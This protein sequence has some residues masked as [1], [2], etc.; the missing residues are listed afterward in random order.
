MKRRPTRLGVAAVTACAG[1]MVAAGCGPSGGPAA[2]RPGRPV[3]VAC[4][5]TLAPRA[6]AAGLTSG[7]DDA[8]PARLPPLPAPEAVSTTTTPSSLLVVDVEVP[9]AMLTQQLEAKLPRRVAEER[10]RDI[11]MAGR[12]QYT[13]DRGSAAARVEAGV[14]VV[15]LPLRV[16][17]EACARSGCYAS[18]A[19]EM[20]ASARVPL[21]LGP[22]Y[23]LHT[24]A[25]TV[26]VTRGCELRVLGGLMSIDVTPILRGALG[27]QTRS[28]QAAIDRELPDLRSEASRLWGALDKPFALPLGGCAL[29]APEGLVQG[30]AGG[31]A[32]LARLRFALMARPEVQVSCAAKPGAPRPLPAL[33]DDPALPALSDVHLA[34]VLPA[35]LPARTIASPDTFELGAAT[36]HV[37]SAEGDVK[38]LDLHL[39]GEACGDVA[40]HA[41]GLA[42]ND[43]RSLSLAGVSVAEEDVPR[44][45][46]SRLEAPRLVRAVEHAALA[47]PLSLDALPGMVPELARAASDPRVSVTASV[48]SAVPESAELRGVSPVAVARVRGAVTLRLR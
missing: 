16:R 8:G 13:V 39:A 19:P 6:S 48:E 22:D 37:E 29:L 46:A 38:R 35:G 43:A 27:S 31:D 12:L 33:R 32:E 3:P 17:V 10:D 28:V 40:V 42:W 45:D 23:K 41:S 25:V 2:L 20:K 7:G 4:G 44:L 5:V 24:S 34:V 30:P 18:C 47:L 1:L 26:D 9:L 36:A 21:R 15:E 11:G 14:L